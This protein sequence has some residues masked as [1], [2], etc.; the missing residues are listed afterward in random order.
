MGAHRNATECLGD[1]IAIAFPVKIG[2]QP[3]FLARHVRGRVAKLALGVVQMTKP[4]DKRRVI[5][6]HRAHAHAKAF[7]MKFVFHCQSVTGSRL[8]ETLR[9]L[10]V[11]YTGC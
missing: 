7:R 11:T 8:P 1:E 3:G 2:F 5:H 9:F 10:A 4:H 6:S